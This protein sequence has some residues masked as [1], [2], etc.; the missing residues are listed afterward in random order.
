MLVVYNRFEDKTKK[1]DLRMYQKN[2]L[3]IYKI[4]GYGLMIL[5]IIGANIYL[6]ATKE[7]LVSVAISIIGIIIGVIFIKLGDKK[8]KNAC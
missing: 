6:F 7:V 4:L 2:K 1:E 5:F 3:N 8:E